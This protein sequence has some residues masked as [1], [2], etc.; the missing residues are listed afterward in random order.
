MSFSE[1][2]LMFKLDFNGEKEKAEQNEQTTK[3]RIAH[4]KQVYS[5]PELFNTQSEDFALVSIA[6]FYSSAIIGS[7]VA[8]PSGRRGN[9][10]SHMARY[11]TLYLS[12]LPRI[13]FED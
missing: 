3:S 8:S 6:G 1:A 5:S 12:S 13:K 2:L 4:V 11:A 9:H 7:M 10:I